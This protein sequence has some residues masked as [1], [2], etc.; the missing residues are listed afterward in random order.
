[1]ADVVPLC[2]LAVF[3]LSL[4]LSVWS[5]AYTLRS[6][7]V[8]QTERLHEVWWSQEM[9][10]TR[11]ETYAMCRA[12]ARDPSALRELV[13]YFQSPLTT[14]EPPGRAAF[15]KLV[16]FF[17]NLEICLHARVVDEQITSHLFAS[18]HYEDYKPLIVA[19]RESIS[20]VAPPGQP[21][22]PWLQMTVNLEKRFDRHGAKFAKLYRAPQA[23]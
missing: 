13:T 11:N 9:M 1:M 2:S 23:R 10:A 21:L 22:P 14:P 12:L 18:A 15:A 7:R 16:G 20:K 3:C 19:L 5:F 6:S 8:T 4:T 17:C